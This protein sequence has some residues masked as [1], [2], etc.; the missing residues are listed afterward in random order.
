M[1]IVE[2]WGWGADFGQ[3]GG[4]PLCPPV[5]IPLKIFRETIFIQIQALQINVSYVEMFRGEENGCAPYGSLQC[6]EKAWF[7]LI[8]SRAFESGAGPCRSVFKDKVVNSE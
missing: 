7:V 5:S 8:S 4:C 6:S 2:R 1:F 3:E